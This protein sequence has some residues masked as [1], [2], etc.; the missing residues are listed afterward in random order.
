MIITNDYNELRDYFYK[1]YIIAYPTDTIYGLGVNAMN[2]EAVNFLY[3][4][5]NRPKNKN[6]ILLVQDINMLKKYALINPKQLQII[7]QLTPHYVTFILKASN[8]VPRWLMDDRGTIAFRIANHPFI[9]EFF[10]YISVPLVSTSANISGFPNAKDGLEVAAYF[11]K[12]EKFAIVCDKWREGSQ[13]SSKSSTIIDVSKEP[14]EVL[15]TGTINIS[16][17]VKR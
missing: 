13:K 1:S 11:N 7:E 4:S 5:K 14:Y 8:Q 6:Y 2:E 16:F 12:L 3:E 10:K 9:S 15:R 17:P